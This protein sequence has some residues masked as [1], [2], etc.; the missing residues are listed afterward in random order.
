MGKFIAEKTI[1]KMI[2][3]GKTNYTNFICH[4][5]RSFKWQDLVFI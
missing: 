5:I 1:K 2:L 4:K 3:A